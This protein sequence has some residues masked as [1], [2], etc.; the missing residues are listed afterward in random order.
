LQAVFLHSVKGMSCTDKN[1]L[2]SV[3]LEG[4]ITVKKWWKRLWLTS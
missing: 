1:T 2:L 4:E 3:V